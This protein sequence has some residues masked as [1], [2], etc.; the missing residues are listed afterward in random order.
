M[1]PQRRPAR[2]H[3]PLG[4]VLAVLSVVAAASPATAG[5]LPASAGGM[6]V[7][8]DRD[9]H[10]LLVDLGAGFDLAFPEAVVSL[11]VS[12][13]A[14]RAEVAGDARFTSASAAKAYWL[15]GAVSAA[16][17]AAAAPHAIAA[18]ALSD[19]AAAGALLD[20][21]GIDVINDFTAAAG[22]AATSLLSWP[23]ATGTRSS[24]RNAGS[25]DN[26]T[27]TN[28]AVR[29]LDQLRQGELLDPAGTYAVLHWMR[30]APDTL[31]GDGDWGGVLTSLLP[32]AVRAR[33]AHKAGWLPPGCCSKD[34]R[35]IIAIGVVP[36]PSG[37]TY[38]VALAA[39]GAAD[40][41]GQASFLAYASRRIY[42]QL[43]A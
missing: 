2:R 30:T 9:L 12:G 5:A 19:N 20:V 25:G 11:T 4:S 27:T 41:A 31:R 33:V 32:P 38:A 3:G 10:D 6:E 22:M 43:A 18:M 36:L 35:L 21:A 8:V 40:Y 37:E 24:D 1:F 42:D 29:F 26:V 39:A 23:T 17:V 14:G 34:H 15:A 16:G 13:P 28:D 7:A